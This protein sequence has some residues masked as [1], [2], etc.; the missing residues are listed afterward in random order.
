MRARLRRWAAIKKA[1]P[2]PAYYGCGWMV[3][4]VGSKGK[5]NYWHNG[6]LPGTSTLLVRRSDGLSWAAVFNQRSDD[7]KLPDTAIDP[8]LHRAADSVA[9]WPETDLFPQYKSV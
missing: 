3:R 8:A 4:P 9:A 1:S 2:L 7:K 6:S 5:A